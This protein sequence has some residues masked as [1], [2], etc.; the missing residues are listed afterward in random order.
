MLSAEQIG[1]A[2]ARHSLRFTGPLLGASDRSLSDDQSDGL[3][4]ER[5]KRRLPEFQGLEP[6]FHHRSI[7]AYRNYELCF[8]A[9]ARAARVICSAQELP[10]A[11]LGDFGQCDGPGVRLGRIS[12]LGSA[13][14]FR[15]TKES[16]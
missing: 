8:L 10:N 2:A 5:P 14:G 16:V 11:S 9:L 12:I 6:C 1:A 13:S 3:R 15:L 7:K 4:T